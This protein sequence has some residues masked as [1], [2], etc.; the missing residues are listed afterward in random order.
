MLVPPVAVALLFII[1]LSFALLVRNMPSPLLSLALALEVLAVT[2]F[3]VPNV[4]P[5]KNTPIEKFD[6]MQF[7]TVVFIWLV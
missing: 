3:I 7:F 5:L 2:L 1:M 6:I 4:A